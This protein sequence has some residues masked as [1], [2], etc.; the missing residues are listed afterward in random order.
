[1]TTVARSEVDQ[2]TARR[3]GVGL[4]A[5][6]EARSAGGY[7]LFAPLTAGGNVYLIDIHGDEVHRWKMPFRPGRDA[8]ILP[9]GNLGYNGNHP[10]SLD[11]YQA[12]ELW[13]GGA[14]SEVTPSGEAVWEY[15]D[16]THHHDAQWLPNGNLLYTCAEELSPTF[17]RRV[18]GGYVPDGLPDRLYGDV[19]KE[20]DRSGN[21]VWQ[22][23]AQDHLDPAA[24][25][26]HDF[27]ARFHWPLVN[28]L[29]EM[30]DGQVLM[31][32]R[33]TSG[34]IAVDKNSGNVTWHL[35][36]DVVAQQHTPV[37]LDNGNILIFDNGN[38]RPRVPGAYTRVIEVNR[39]TKQIE[40]QYA[41]N[42]RG[43]FFSAYM[44]SAQRLLNGN[45]FVT[46][47]AFGRLFEVT[48]E[49]EVVW[50]YVIPYFAEFPE[51]SARKHTPGLQNQVFRSH[52]YTKADIPWL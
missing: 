7:T 44:G 16:P 29:S 10:T 45:T 4:I 17:A 49:C 6:D 37:E 9:N 46:E 51:G 12:W 3:R 43:A 41:D 24:F 42:I 32:L 31:S 52:R 39:A 47:P 33:M 50:E 15:E 2:V 1:M 40:W 8:V 13:H 20:V 18:P 11:F 5:V 19:I 35:G 30:R 48:P 34:V 27:F 21:I 38:M 22:W 26:I 23:R 28:G 25:P 36:S 14:F